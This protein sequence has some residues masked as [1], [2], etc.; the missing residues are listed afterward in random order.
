MVHSPGNTPNELPANPTS[1]PRAVGLLGLSLTDK[2]MNAS[3]VDTTASS[4]GNIIKFHP[5]GQCSNETLAILGTYAAPHQYS[6]NSSIVNN[7]LK[8]MNK[9]CDSYEDDK[10]GSDDTCD[11]DKTTAAASSNKIEYQAQLQR[12]QHQNLLLSKR[13]DNVLKS[14]VSLHELYET[15]LDSISRMN[16]MNFVP[17]N[18]MPDIPK[19]LC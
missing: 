17:D 13:R 9:N 1:L 3:S 6:T 10:G 12:L 8:T 2:K 14:L 16:D 4:A 18:V 19:R 5:K 7:D 11:D 15:G